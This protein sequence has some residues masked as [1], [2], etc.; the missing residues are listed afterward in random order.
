[1]SSNISLRETYG[2]TLVQLGRSNNRIVVLDADLSKSTMTCYFE[3][4][5]PDRFFEMVI[6][7]QNMVS[8]SVGLSLTGKIPFCNTF[9]FFMTGRV[10]DQ[11][12]AAAHMKANIKLVGSSSG[13]SDN[14]DGATHQSVEDISLMRSLP[15]MTVLVPSD[16]IEIRKMTEFM[17]KYNGPVYMRINKQ[18]MPMV[19]DEEFD[20]KLGDLNKIREGKDIAVIANGYMVSKSLEAAA[21]LKEK[22]VSIAV[23]NAGTVKPID[24]EKI[25]KIADSFKGIIVVEEHS[26]IGGLGSAILETLMGKNN[27]PISLIGIEDQFGRSSCGYEELLDFYG[28]SVNRIVNKIE[29]FIERY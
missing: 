21:T 2:K 15:N 17:A 9:F 16:A 22:G 28:L 14:D 8:T 7:E 6:A 20:F 18:K 13:L 25:I 5:F 11:V 4:E 12:R 3:E 19:F 1:M 26:V 29:K 10:Y 23:Y 27:I 24:R